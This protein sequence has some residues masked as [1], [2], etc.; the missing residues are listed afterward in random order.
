[1]L[2]AQHPQMVQ[3]IIKRALEIRS[4]AVCTCLT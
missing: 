1:M 3:R 2:N 4:G